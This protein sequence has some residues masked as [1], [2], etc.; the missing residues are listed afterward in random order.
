[1]QP[2]A[3]VMR[4]G[5]ARRGIQPVQHPQAGTGNPVQQLVTRAQSQVLGQIRQDQ[6][7]L[8]FRRQVLGQPGQKALQ[9]G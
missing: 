3:A 4:L 6:P 9:H 1:M 7:A 2:V 5:V 8:A